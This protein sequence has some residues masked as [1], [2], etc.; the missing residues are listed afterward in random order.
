MTGRNK[1]ALTM[2]KADAMREL[3]EKIMQGLESPEEKT[4]NKP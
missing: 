4:E 2:V 1:R 3:A